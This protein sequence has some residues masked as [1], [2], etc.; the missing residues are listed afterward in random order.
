MQDLSESQT[1]KKKIDV[2]LA[3]QGWNVQDRSKVILEVDTK[4]SNFIDKRYVTV[5]ETLK[6]DLESKYADYLL[7]DTHGA[8]LAIIEAKRTTKDPMLGQRQAEE[9]ANDIKSQTGNDVFIFLSNGYEI[10]FWDRERYP[11]RQIKGFYARK[12]L[13]RL[14]FQI[15]SARDSN[16]PG[17][18]PEIVNRPKS[19]ENVKRVV[20]HLHSGHRKALIVMATGTG[21]TRVAMG[22]IDIL[23][24]ENRAQKVLFLAD[25]VALGKQTFDDGF[26]R[27]FPHE[28]KEIISGGNFDRSKRHYVSTIQTFEKLYL[29]K[30]MQGQYIISPGEFD[31]VISDE[32][33]RSIY[34]KWKD[35]FTYLDAIQ[36]GLTA[37]P[38]ELVE[39]D[40]FRFFN[41]LDGKPTAMYSFDDAV[42]DGI[43]CDFRAHIQGAKTH[44]Q[45]KG[46]RPA[47]LPESERTRLIEQGIDP[48]EIDFEGTELEKKVSIKGTSEA[49]IR[50]FM[51][52]CQTD[53]TGTR[54]A[55]SI[56]FAMSKKHARSLLDAFELLYP[57][58]KGTLARII[59]SDDQRAS[60][61]IASFKKEQEIRIA[62]SVDMLDTGIDIPEVCNLVFAKPV[63]SKIKFWQ[64]LGH[65][66]RSDGACSHREW[67]PD[68]KKEFF[69]VFDFCGN[70]EY[71]K[72]NPKGVESKPVE[73]V[74]SKIFLQRVRQLSL[75]LENGDQ[76]LA[77]RIK[78]QIKEDIDSLPADSV[79][80][81]EHAREI[82]KATS[83][84]FY[85][86][87]GINP[88]D[89]LIQKIMPLMK[90]QQDVNLQTATFNLRC[91]QLA[92]A[93]LS[94]NQG[95]VERLKP[96]IGEM[97]NNLPIS[98]DTVMAQK[99]LIDRVLSSSFW[100][101]ITY[102]DTRQ[103]IATLGSLMPM[104]RPEHYEP[105]VI[106]MGDQI[107]QR[108]TG[109]WTVAG[110][111]PAYITKFHKLVERRI[112]DLAD[113]DPVLMK[114]R[115]GEE[116]TEEDIAALEKAIF[117]PSLI[118]DAPKGGHP[119][120]RDRGMLISFLKEL[121]GRAAAPD[122]ESRIRDAFQTFMIENNKHYSADQLNFIR[123]IESVFAK[124][125]RLAEEDLW[126]PPFSNF[127]TDA[128]VPM[129]P[130]DDLAA[131]VGICRRL[132]CE[133]FARAEA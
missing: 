75:L 70:F 50:E 66:T 8:P 22:I 98:I 41:C 105:I 51:E 104:M 124:N 67:L 31:V 21:K 84:N 15:T 86:N 61:L 36:I 27:F 14:R 19:I 81:R 129:F 12:D 119:L 120:I 94:G 89:Y 59:V 79:S 114:V 64:M 72:M 85:D 102:E 48:D 56:I 32:A 20:E 39:H 88:V 46:V 93:V 17:V 121:I 111:E 92:F 54:P 110:S 45:L 11:P 97:V 33:H 126:G 2:F 60:A 5:S 37:T 76:A 23:M 26:K 132:E 35:V 90:H 69:V 57:E 7:L 44:F 103:M 115:N 116:L 73:A 131:F 118:P 63:F 38:A 122:P 6:N 82:E 55:K 78:A 123:T 49:I 109:I 47:D 112:L 100:S 43:L 1:R 108:T 74:T 80:V 10:S 3:E 125:C 106:D 128:P 96:L 42:A 130:E 13:E 101:S 28:A 29:K 18:N 62:I 117:D 87:V 16:I 95:E 4:Q 127:G 53:E 65:G 133:L 25:R 52:N 107:E 113:E 91:E 9:Y 24:R 68:G 34:N 77:E 83:P 58:Y 71:W 30:D 99:P 40:T